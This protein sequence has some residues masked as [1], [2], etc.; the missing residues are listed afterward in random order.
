MIFSLTYHS[1]ICEVE[2]VSVKSTIS[3][4][5]SC[6]NDTLPLHLQLET[7][8]KASTKRVHFDLSANREHASNHCEEDLRGLW[9]SE[10]EYKLLRQVA[11]R[12]ARSVLAEARANPRAPFSYQRVMEQTYDTC[13]LIVNEEMEQFE[14][15]STPQEQ[16]HLYRWAEFA[17]SRMGLEK[18]TLRHIGKDAEERR[19]DIYDFVLGTQCIR[20]KNSCAREDKAEYIRKGCERLSRPSR[21]YARAI[22]KA[23]ASSMDYP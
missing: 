19:L 18:Y 9:Y 11:K 14:S 16:L 7:P 8:A 3:V 23:R 10:S 6:Q 4:D 20:V 12:D 15:M 22:A 5:R 17:T 13:A 2:D 21:I 1:T